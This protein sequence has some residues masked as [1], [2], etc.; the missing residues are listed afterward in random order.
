MDVFSHSDSKAWL[1]QGFWWRCL[2]VS[3]VSVLGSVQVGA[4]APQLRLPELSTPVW[5]LLRVP[6]D[7]CSLS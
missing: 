5:S 1:C 4:A 6:V 2:D 3:L 7:F